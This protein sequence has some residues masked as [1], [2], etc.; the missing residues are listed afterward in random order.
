MRNSGPWLLQQIA[1]CI[2][3]LVFVPFASATA[4]QDPG[5]NARS[6]VEGDSS[7]PAQSGAQQP[8]AAPSAAETLPN[9]PG[10]IRWQTVAESLQSSGQQASTPQQSAPQEPVGTAVAAP[11]NSTGVVAS[12][13]AGAAIAPAKQRRARSIMIKVGAIVGASVAVGTVV[14]LSSASPSRPSGSR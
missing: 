5:T 3:L 14:A 4:S 7:A 11:A 12:R 13:P 2:A 8:T 6:Q 1:G 10:S 9:S